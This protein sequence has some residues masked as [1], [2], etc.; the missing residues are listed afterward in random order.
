[1]RSAGV[2]QLKPARVAERATAGG[3]SARL[4]LSASTARAERNNKYANTTVIMRV[5]H[6]YCVIFSLL[7]V[8]V[9]FAQAEMPPAFPTGEYKLSLALYSKNGAKLDSGTAHFYFVNEKTKNV[10]DTTSPLSNGISYLLLD[11]GMWNGYVEVDYSQTPAADYFSQT[12]FSVSTDANRSLQLYEIAS[13]HLIVK[14][15]EGRLVPNAQVSVEC[16]HQSTFAGNQTY[17]TLTGT[18]GN[19]GSILLDRIHAESCYISVTKDK[20][21]SVEAVK[22]TSGQLLEK[23]V[24][25]TQEVGT[26]FDLAFLLMVSIVILLA[27]LLIIFYIYGKEKKKMD[28][29]KHEHEKKEKAHARLHDEHLLLKKEHEA[30][31][32]QVHE[33]KKAQKML[34]NVVKKAAR[35]S[36]RM[37]AQEKK[38]TAHAVPSEAQ[39]HSSLSH[40]TQTVLATN[41][42]PSSSPVYPKKLENVLNTLQERE[43]KI[44]ELVFANKGQMKSSKIRH[45]LLLPKSSLS[46]MLRALERKNIISISPFGNSMAVRLQDWLLKNDDSS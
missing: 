43:R 7:L 10:V 30:Q 38:E 13:A 16:L 36:T 3:I 27:V 41:P 14:D 46:R 9:I 6:I 40:V 45:E 1:M 37:K 2:F 5:N 4:A 28:A 24:S 44:V 32:K 34:V 35:D 12:S 26:G 20:F 39:A 23:T 31:K 22:L 19:D 21:A 8:S 18:T 17:F 33:V 29:H 42:Q 15:K 25:L 11:S